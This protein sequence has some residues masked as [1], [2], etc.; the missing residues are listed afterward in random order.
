MKK[1]VKKKTWEMMKMT[2]CSRSIHET[3]MAREDF[4]NF[5]PAQRDVLERST[6]D[7][8][9]NTYIC[10]SVC[11]LCLKEYEELTTLALEAAAG[12]VMLRCIRCDEK[13]MVS[14]MVTNIII[15]G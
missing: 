5:S 10:V 1:N 2:R 3:C 7:R 14:S 8:V 6:C 4:C 13:S 9:L 11:S 12:N 15:S